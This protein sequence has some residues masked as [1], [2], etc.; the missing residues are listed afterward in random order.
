[1]A[2][3]PQLRVHLPITLPLEVEKKERFLLT[4]SLFFCNFAAV[5]TKEESKTV[6]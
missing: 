2:K 1:M 6:F 5:K 4:F 3:T